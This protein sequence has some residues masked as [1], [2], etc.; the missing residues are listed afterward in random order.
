[1]TTS[2]KYDDNID[3]TFLAAM[4][5][6]V[7]QILPWQFALSHPDLKGRFMWYPE[8]GSLIYE[9][10]E[11]GVSKVG[12]FTDSEDVWGQIQRKINEV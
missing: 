10:P 8:K 9:L 5:V 2:K 12:E 11:W 3:Y 1:M 7:K 6:T 4:D